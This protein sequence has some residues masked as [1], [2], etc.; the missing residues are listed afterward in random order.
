[1][2]AL[3]VY[4][5]ERGV[6]YRQLWTYSNQ[7]GDG[8]NKFCGDLIGVIDDATMFAL[9]MKALDHGTGDLSAFDDDQFSEAVGMEENGI[10]IFYCYDAHSP[11]AYYAEPQPKNW[12]TKTLAELNLSRPKSLD[13]KTPKRTSHKS[14]LY[15]LKQQ[16]GST[17]AS[18]LAKFAELV[19]QVLPSKMRN[20]LVTVLYSKKHD[21]A[22]SLDQDS[23]Q[24]FYD[25]LLKHQGTP[26][27][28]VHRRI[29]SLLAGISRGQSRAPSQKQTNPTK[30]IPKI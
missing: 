29:Q 6:Q 7:Q 3:A 12:P 19:G 17:A 25:Y 15:W 1:M 13:C 23:L 20:G 11:L 30:K 10:P 28:D 24:T 8:A 21:E 16:S 9:E 22:L 18:P 4:F 14:L 27:S 5:R 26:G 2:D